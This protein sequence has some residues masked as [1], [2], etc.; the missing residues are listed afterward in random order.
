MKQTVNE[1]V[2]LL[3]T[4]MG[5]TQQDFA[6]LIGLTSTQLSRIENGESSPQ[7]NTIKQIVENTGVDFDWL[8]TGKGDIKI[9]AVTSKTQVRDPWQDITY[10]E[11]RE[12]NTYLQGKLNE[13]MS[14]LSRVLERGN[15]GKLKA[16]GLAGLFRMEG[17]PEV[18]A[19]N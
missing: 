18:R 5:K 15:L 4:H 17:R 12:T 11:L 2:K 1:R 13:A 19:K 7:K 6:G 16:S 9:H 3:R 10:K 8:M 14:M